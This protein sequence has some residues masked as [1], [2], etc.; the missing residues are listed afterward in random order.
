MFI[1]SMLCGLGLPLS[2]S[3]LS[4]SIQVFFFFYNNRF[5]FNVHSLESE[6]LTR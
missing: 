3:W 6:R 4:S 1:V 2:L 5:C